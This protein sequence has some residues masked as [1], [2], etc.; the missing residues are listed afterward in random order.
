MA[1]AV[2]RFRGTSNTACPSIQKCSLST[3]RVLGA[4]L[5]LLARSRS[6]DN[7]VTLMDATRTSPDR[8]P[9]GGRRSDRDR[10]KCDSALVLLSPKVRE[11]GGVL[12]LRAL[13]LLRC[14]LRRDPWG[15]RMVG[16]AA[17]RWLA[18]HDWTG[19]PRHQSGAARYLVCPVRH[20]PV[21]RQEGRLGCPSVHSPEHGYSQAR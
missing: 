19:V 15:S 18:A 13:Q 1:L 10:G 11:Q 5:G 17:S 16:L 20:L 6:A 21:G 7:G 8:A 14:L 3:C 9:R 4:E 2:I 12:F